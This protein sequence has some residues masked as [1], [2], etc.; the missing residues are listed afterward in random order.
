[1]IA[2]SNE[3][4]ALSQLTLS[5]NSPSKSVASKPVISSMS[6][7]DDGGGISPFVL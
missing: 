6:T 7:P 2:D 1:M 4:A 5:I 3:L